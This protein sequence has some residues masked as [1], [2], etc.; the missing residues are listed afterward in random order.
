MSKII[1]WKFVRNLMR[2]KHAFSL[3]I[4]IIMIIIFFLNIAGGKENS[5]QYFSKNDFSFFEEQKIIMH[6]LTME[7]RIQCQTAIEKIYWAQRTWPKEN[8]KPKPS[9]KELIK[10]GRIRTKIEDILKKSNALE[11]YWK[12]PITGEQL[13]AEIERIAIGTRK[14][15]ILKQIWDALDNN[16][17]LI[18]ECLARPNIA[19]RMIRNWYASDER[20]HGE[21]KEK[22]EAEL[23]KYL[24]PSQMK[25]MSGKYIE[26]EWL[27][28]EIPFSDA[29]I[30]ALS[31]GIISNLKENENIY[32]AL[33]VLEK[34]NSKMRIASI[35]WEKLSFDSWWIGIRNNIPIELKYYEYNY[36]LPPIKELSCTYDSGHR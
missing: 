4:F 2:L 5:I 36:E 12:K 18:A 7:E 26:K 8:L 34:D 25:L 9:F 35:T 11:I 17:Y 1:S 27:K 10:K 21:I 14:P 33:A 32:Y 23:K 28:S 29:E 15:Q 6:S 22:A 13:Q 3:L 31:V 19:D 16:P 24:K 30:N 20:F